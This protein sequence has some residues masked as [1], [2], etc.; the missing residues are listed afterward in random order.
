M[1][2][3]ALIRRLQKLTALKE[4]PSTLPA[5]RDEAARA[6]ERLSAHLNEGDVLQGLNRFQR[7]QHNSDPMW[8]NICTVLN[9]ETRKIWPGIRPKRP[10]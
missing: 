10:F 3:D 8:D 7:I 5:I 6:K 1:N 2:H 4:H 9:R